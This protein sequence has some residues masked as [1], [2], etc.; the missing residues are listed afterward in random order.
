MKN[1]CITIL[2]VLFV[3]CSKSD[4]SDGNIGNQNLIEVF[5]FSHDL[6]HLHS[7]RNSVH[8]INGDKADT[9]HIIK[10]SFSQANNTHRIEIWK[11]EEDT[12][13]GI[14]LCKSDTYIQYSHCM[15]DFY[16][17]NKT[18]KT[19]EYYSIEEG[20]WKTVEQ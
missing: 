18:A 4:S 9:S 15:V 3:S 19:V 11:K 12:I 6:A 17:D 7:Y 2:L 20:A 8:G 1:L 13:P 16:F 5:E 14:K 10:H